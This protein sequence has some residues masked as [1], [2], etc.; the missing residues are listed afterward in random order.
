MCRLS[1]VLVIWLHI[2][3]SDHIPRGPRLDAPGALHHVIARGI[4][5][6][7][8]FNDD[9]DR[10]DLLQRLAALVGCSGTRLY[11][12]ALLSN[13]FHLLLRTGTAPLSSLL[14][15]VLTGYA[16]SF[17]R[18]HRRGRHL[19]Q[20]RFQSI[21]VEDDPYLLTLVRYRRL[22]RPGRQARVAVY[23]DAVARHGLSPMAR[24]L[25]ISMQSVLRAT[26]FK[27]VSPAPLPR[28]WRRR[29]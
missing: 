14:R 2:R 26:L 6:R 12:W 3:Y 27:P 22:R 18:R 24:F 5:R 17:N 1:T 21:L 13:H 23:R 7:A 11:A 15:R 19:F 28:R 29:G 10:A 16:V 9:R 25:N 20:N 4:E 8:L